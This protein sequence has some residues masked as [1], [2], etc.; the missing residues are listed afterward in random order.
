MQ[1]IDLCRKYKVKMLIASFA[2]DPSGMKSP[3]DLISLFK[4]LGCENPSFLGN[5]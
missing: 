3:H 5:V 2:K 4:V 1:N